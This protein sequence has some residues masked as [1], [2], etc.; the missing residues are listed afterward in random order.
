[1]AGDEPP[2]CHEPGCRAHSCLRRPQLACCRLRLDRLVPLP[3]QV[4]E[5][6]TAL[7]PREGSS[8]SGPC[9][10]GNGAHSHSQEEQQQ[11]EQEAQ[12]ADGGGE[13]ADLPFDAPFAPLR[14]PFDFWQ[15]GV[16]LCLLGGA[17][18]AF[19]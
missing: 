5:A 8:P 2:R 10:A 16:L 1:M 3:A 4:D 18:G 11:E 14:S 19:G 7:S 13:K 9:N 6:A 12:E 17:L 15:D